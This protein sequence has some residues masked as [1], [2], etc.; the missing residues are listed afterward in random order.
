MTRWSLLRSIWRLTLTVLVPL[1]L[2]SALAYPLLP[3]RVIIHY[4][5]GGADGYS[6]AAFAVLALP[7]TLLVLTAVVSVWIV[8]GPQ[9]PSGRWKG[10]WPAVLLLITVAHL[11]LVLGSF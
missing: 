1:L 11:A 7:A 6:A 9:L 4:S 8:A 10:G 2:V 3:D 5:A